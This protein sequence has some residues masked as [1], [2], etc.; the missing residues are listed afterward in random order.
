M[1]LVNNSTLPWRGL[2]MQYKICITEFMPKYLGQITKFCI[3]FIFIFF[4]KIGS[5]INLDIW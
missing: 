3:S 1:K 2:Y 5:I 4:T